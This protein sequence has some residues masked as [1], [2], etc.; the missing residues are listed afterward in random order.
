MR[1]PNFLFILADDLGYADLGCTG[2][3]AQVSPNLDR[4]AADGMLFTHG[5]A[6]SP[7]CSPTRFALITGRWQ[8]RLR[9]A[10]EE[11]MTGRFRGDKVVGLPPEHPTLPS[12]LRDAGYRTALVGKWHLGYPPHFG[13]L[14]SGYQE[15][16]GPLSGGVDYFSYTSSAGTPD[17]WDG[18]IPAGDHGYLTDALSDR[19]VRFIESVED[20]P[21]LLSLHYTAPHWPWETREDRA[22]SERIGG[23]ISHL[24][25]GSLA[26]Y[27]R[28]IQQMDEG[29][30]RVLAALESKGLADDTLVVFTSDNGGERFS[31]NWP[32]VGQKMDLLEGGIRVP[33]IARWPACIRAGSTTATPAIT[34][35]WC[36]TMLAAA[37]VAPHP[38]YP[39]DGM[40]LLPL[41]ADPAWEPQRRLY[42][43]MLHRQQAAL[44][45]GRWKYLAMDGHEYLFDL[46]ADERERANLAQCQAQRLASMRETWAEWNARL[47]AIPPDARATLVFSDADIP[48]PS[49]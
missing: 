22:E 8:Y 40:S 18:E 28:M 9:G 42:W 46:A 41:F 17:L 30:G 25:G 14:K 36:A 1:R 32:F 34:M 12:L 19:A 31:D 24:D 15:F 29:I 27:H 2:A 16:F 11:P 20:A 3:R 37:G 49:H 23:R 43:R 39:L 4:M 7:V 48:R 44:R 47:P 5:Y 10:A 21:F 35:D 38:E 13:P 45:D 33:L 6:N 26:T